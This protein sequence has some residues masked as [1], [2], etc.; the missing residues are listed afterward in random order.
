MTKRLDIP[1]LPPVTRADLDAAAQRYKNWG[2]W[3]PDDE[4]GTLNFTT[5]EDIVQAAKLVRKGRVLS[6]GLKFDAQGPQGGKTKY[7]P[8]GRFNPIHVMLRTGTDAYA[9]VLD[10]RGIRA[11][12]DMV[13]MPLQCSTQWDGLGHIFFDSQMWN[14]YD[15]RLV[16]S[17]GAQK[18]GIV[19]GIDDDAQPRQC[20][21]D[22]KA[23]QKCGAAAQ[24]IRDAHQLQRFFQRT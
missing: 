23:L 17:F 4:L 1:T 15:C 14:G 19:L 6:L 7:P 13:I 18:C 9:G 24:V 11:A 16:S 5:P 3:G 8:M 22:F 20:V 12:D 2:R 21:L 10:A